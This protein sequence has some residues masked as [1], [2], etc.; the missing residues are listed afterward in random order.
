M[1]LTKVFPGRKRSNWQDMLVPF[2]KWEVTGTYR[3]HILTYKSCSVSVLA[4]ILNPVSLVHPQT[5]NPFLECGLG[6][7]F[8]DSN[9][10]SRTSMGSCLE[11]VEC[12]PITCTVLFPNQVRRF[13]KHFRSSN[14]NKVRYR[15]KA[16]QLARYA[17]A[18]C[19]VGSHRNIPEPH[20]NIQKL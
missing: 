1:D 17:R 8:F 20:S 15:P 12:V 2:A 9:S 19:Q 16:Q 6:P 4:A 13:R 11:H 3:N 5:T 10:F 7:S 18:V 14:L